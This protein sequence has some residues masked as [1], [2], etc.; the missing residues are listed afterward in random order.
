MLFKQK[1]VLV[2]LFSLF[3]I[4]AQCADYSCVHLKNIH[5]GVDMGDGVVYFDTLCGVVNQDTITKPYIQD[6]RDRYS[7]E[8]AIAIGLRQKKEASIICNSFGLNKVSKK[9]NIKK[10]DIENLSDAAATLTGGQRMLG[11]GYGIGKKFDKII[12]R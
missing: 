11:F 9:K 1:K 5:R 4:S 2:G 3:A 12:C 6:S 7:N 10:V 8:Y